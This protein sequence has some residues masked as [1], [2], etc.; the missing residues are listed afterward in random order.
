MF[1]GFNLGSALIGFVA[2]FL[3]PDH[4]WQS[5]L[6]FGGALPLLVLPILF[7][8]LPESARFLAAK[9]Y[10]P[11]R[12]RAALGRVC[13]A[14]LADY[15]AFET[16]EAAPATKQ[17]IRVLFSSG[18]TLRT[19]TLW[20]TYFMGLLVI[21]LT[22]SWLPTMMKDAGIPI[23]RSAQITAMFQLGGTIGAIVVGLAMDRFRP[24]RTIALSYLLGGAALVAL[25]TGGVASAML[26]LLVAIVGFFLS[27][28]Q[29]GLNA[30][31]PTCY[32]TIA[33]ATGTSWMLG[34]GRLGSIL[35]S[36]I[37][38]LLLSLGWGFEAIFMALAVPAAVAAVSIL[39]NRRSD[40]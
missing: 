1:T 3:V 6:M 4:G 20:L 12:I 36:S 39:S 31:A 37:G 5:V 14:D 13:K 19:V 33:R 10:D 23:E 22:T 29:T 7:A 18:Y 30:F 34:I 32:P 28:A 2:A 24:N 35:G 40:A 9:G 21:Y 8:F 11:E 16:R 25:A 26:A 38:G 15:T 27:G 17:P